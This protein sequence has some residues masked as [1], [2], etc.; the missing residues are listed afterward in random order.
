MLRSVTTV[1]LL[2]SLFALVGG[3]LAA[4]CPARGV[5]DPCVPEAIPAGGFNPREVYVETSSVQ[6]RTRTCMVFRLRGNPECV[7]E[8]GT[9][10]VE[11]CGSM[12]ACVRTYSGD[13][14]PFSYP[15]SLERVFC[16]CRC[17]APGGA[18][19][20]LCQCGEG[21]HCVDVLTAGGVG[22]AGGY[23]V[24]NQYCTADEDC[25]SGRCDLE[26]GL[27]VEPT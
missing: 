27:C 26:A 24:P 5:G 7:M 17:R 14:N 19:Q 20:P 23:C 4:G 25:P 9:C 10:S 12:E 11:R 22:I 6:C 1:R 18:N 2:G 16:T 3:L 21:Y 13:A 15:N 8:R